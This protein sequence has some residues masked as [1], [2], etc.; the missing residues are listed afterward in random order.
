MITELKDIHA[1]TLEEVKRE[2]EKDELLQ[3]VIHAV[4]SNGTLKKDLD[5]DAYA[6]VISELS[7]INGLLLRGERWVMPEKLQ[8]KVVDA[9]HEGHQGITKT[10]SFLRSRL[11]FAGMDAMVERMIRDC[12]A[13][14]VVTME[15][16][17]V[18]FYGPLPTGGYL[19][20]VTCK[21]S[22]YP[23]IEIVTSTAAKAVIPHFER[24][25]SEFGY[26]S[27]VT[28]DNGPPFR[29][30]E[31]KEYAARS[32]FVVRNITLGEP[33]VN[34]Q[35]ER[36]MKNIA[37]TIQTAIVDKKD[38]RNE[39]LV[40]LHNYRATPHQIMG[41]YPAE[42]MFPNCNFKNESANCKTSNAISSR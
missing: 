9:A 16:V 2:R 23:L 4:K 5:I 15:K 6:N 11:W 41:K 35:A 39:L 34:G 33:K 26:P 14:Q 42:L 13:C 24:I 36:F 10:K 12:L 21:Y 31:F 1:I 20:L 7:V 22:R 18:D 32:G 40:F 25:F 37:K 28:A 27:E 38:W 19:L 29:S 30:Q 3:K 17:A 8:K